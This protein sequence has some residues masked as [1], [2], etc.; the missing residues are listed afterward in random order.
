MLDLSNK[1]GLA[2][3][4]VEL[5]AQEKKKET[6]EKHIQRC[7]EE[8]AK[9]RHEQHRVFKNIQMGKDNAKARYKPE[10]VSMK[11]SA[12]S[13]VRNSRSAQYASSIYHNAKSCPLPALN[14]R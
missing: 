2:V 6:R 9:L 13:K 4:S 12:E 5:A 1:L 3:T 11:D 10:K 8:P 7:S 14:K